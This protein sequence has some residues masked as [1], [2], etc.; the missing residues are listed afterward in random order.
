MIKKSPYKLHAVSTLLNITTAKVVK[1]EKNYASKI[2]QTNNGDT[3]IAANEE[4]M[5][6]T[7]QKAGL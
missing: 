3:A 5:K 4:R 1:K 6:E 2:E 7:L